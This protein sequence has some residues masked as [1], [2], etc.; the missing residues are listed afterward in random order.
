MYGRI[1]TVRLTP[2]AC[3]AVIDALELAPATNRPIVVHRV[4]LVPTQSETNQQIQ[5]LVFTLG[6][7]A[8]SGSSGAAAPTVGAKSS[9][10]AAAGFTAENF[11]T[12]IATTAGTTY[13][14]ADDAFPA[15]GGFAYTPD[16]TERPVVRAGEL[17]VVRIAE[18]AG[19]AI[20]GGHAIVEEI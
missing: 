19:G 18:T 16:V 4:V 20:I 5:V 8:T 7:A 3:S 15:Q 13:Y 14:H 12:T 11:N 6:A 1:Y 9:M 10:D 17:F 2:T